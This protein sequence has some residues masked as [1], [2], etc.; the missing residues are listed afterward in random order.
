MTNTPKDPIE[1]MLEAELGGWGEVGRREVRHIAS[2]IHMYVWSAYQIQAT[3][4]GISPINSLEGC[5][6]VR[7]AFLNEAF[8]Q[9]E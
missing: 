3:A 4:Q 5:Y 2:L 1:R 9:A 7:M 8:P 6:A